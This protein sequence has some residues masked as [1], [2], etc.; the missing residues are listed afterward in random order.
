M[1]L[2]ERRGRGT[3]P[4]S[5]VGW[6]SADDGVGGDGCRGGVGGGGGTWS[7]VLESTGKL[8]LKIQVLINLFT[9]IHPDFLLI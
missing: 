5:H 6:Y 8:S 9:A 1:G 3:L 7:F 4:T 2:P